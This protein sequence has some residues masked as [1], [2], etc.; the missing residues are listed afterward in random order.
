VIDR[1]TEQDIRILEEF[2]EFWMKFH[3]VYGGLIMRATI[4]EEDES[5]FLEQKEMIGKKYEEL[6]SA[7]DFRYTQHGRL[8]DPVSDILALEGV[9]LMSEKNMHKREDDWRDSYVFLNSILERLKN[10]KRR[11][12]QFNAVG[13]FF[14]R[15]LERA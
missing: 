12:E 7:L 9:R 15:V 1:K 8:T 14:K 3:T 6:V 13:V 11:L 4:S 5:K 10:K 2:L